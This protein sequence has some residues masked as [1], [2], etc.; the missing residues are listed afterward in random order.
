MDREIDIAVRR[1]RRLRKIGIGGTVVLAGITLGAYA[2]DWLRPSVHRSHTRF[3][4]IERGDLEAT[5]VASGTVVPVSERVV[6]CP[7]DARVERVR[8]RPGEVV[9]Q[10]TQ[11]LELDTSATRLQIE[12]LDEQLAQNGNDRQQAG[13]QLEER[14]SSLESGIEAKKLDL[15]IA[16]FRLEQHR[17]LREGGLIAEEA[18]LEAEVVAR[19]AEIE[20]RRMSQEILAE[21]RLNDARLARLAMD[22]SILRKE[23]DDVRRQLE[24]ADT[25]AP[26]AGVLTSVF[27][28]VGATVQRGQVLARIADLESFRVEAKVSDAYAARLAVGQDV[29]VLVD[30]ARLTARVAGIL[31][32]I[33]E[34]TVRFNVDLDDASNALLRHNRRVEVLV[35]TGRRRDVLRAPRGPYIRDGGDRQ[36]VFVVDDDHARRTDVTIGLVGHEFYE[37]VDGLEEGDEIIVSDVRNYIHAERIRLK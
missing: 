20:L 25:G 18:V 6:S 3:G 26:V 21:R 8:L 11:I 9:E 4:R 16:K 14:I 32:T 5:L 28:E 36:A 24:L 2:M 19:K 17:K 30:D 23:R 1:R 34:G 15:E 31:P 29:H 33:E 27:E 7:V 12:R 35:V 22:G 10:G 13:L 37:V